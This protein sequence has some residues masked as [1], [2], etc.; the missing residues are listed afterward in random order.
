MELEMG[1]NGQRGLICLAELRLNTTGNQYTLRG[2][3]QRQ[4][5]ILFQRN[6]S[7]SVIALLGFCVALGF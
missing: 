6:N 7:I 3:Q 2:N 4:V 1:A 5:R